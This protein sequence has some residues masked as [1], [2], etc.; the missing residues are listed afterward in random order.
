MDGQV[1]NGME[2]GQD[3]AVAPTPVAGG[4]VFQFLSA[5][6]LYSCGVDTE[7]A[8]HCWGKNAAQQ[9]GSAEPN[10]MAP[11]PVRSRRSVPV[12][13]TPAASPPMTW[14]SVG[15]QRVRTTGQRGYNGPRD[16]RARSGTALAENIRI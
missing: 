16:A 12:G 13:F 2:A 8:A 4:I 1:G 15:R 3:I 11:V 9:L 10:S 6:S 14:L 5:G 7:G